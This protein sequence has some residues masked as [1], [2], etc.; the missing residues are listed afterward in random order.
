MKNSVFFNYL[1]YFND[2]NEDEITEIKNKI[3]EYAKK[4]AKLYVQLYSWHPTLPTM[5]TILIQGSH[6]IRAIYIPIGELS[7][8]ATEACNKQ[9]HL[10]W[11]I[12][13][14]KFSWISCNHD[15]FNRL[16]LSSDSIL[17]GMRPIIRKKS[18]S[19]FKETLEILLPVETSQTHETESSEWKDDDDE[20]SSNEK[21]NMFP[22]Y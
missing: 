17:T 21:R 18:K 20:L 6:Y 7:E 5:H 22:I 15:V 9:F 16:L 11:Q 8:E 13:S 10:F 19:F 12:L 3:I 2:F 4:A 1:L 14:R